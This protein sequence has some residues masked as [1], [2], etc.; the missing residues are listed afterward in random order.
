MGYILIS[1]AVTVP[2]LMILTSIGFEESL[3][4]GGQIDTYTVSSMLTFSKQKDVS[5]LKCTPVCK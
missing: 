5:I 3:A 4:R 2:T 1:E